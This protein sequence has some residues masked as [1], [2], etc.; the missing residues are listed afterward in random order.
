MRNLKYKTAYT[1]L[2]VLLVGISVGLVRAQDDSGSSSEGAPPAAT[3]TEGPNV[4]NPPLSGLDQPTSE[5]AFGGRSYV[6]PGLQVSES[7]NTNLAGSA[8]SGTNTAAI[9]T[10]LGSMDLQK[11]WR[12]YQLGLDYIAGGSYYTGPTVTSG[13][14]HAYQVHTLAADQRILWRTG[15]LSIRDTFDYLPE[16]A[17]GFNSYGGAGAFSSALGNGVSG[18]GAGTGLG[19]GLTGGSPAGLYAGN[20]YGTLG[21]QPR[22]DNSSIIDIVQEFSP[23]TAVTLGGGYSFSHY[24]DTASSPFPIINSQQ[25]TG[26]VGY[27]YLLNARDQIGLL[28]AFQEFQ[29][30]RAGGGS[31]TAHVWNVLYGHRI[32]GRLNFTLAGGPQ[33]IFIHNPMQVV[34]IPPLGT[35]T[36]PASVTRRVSGNGSVTL[37]YTVSAR[38]SAQVRYQHYVTPGSGFYA[39]ANTDAVR[40]SLGHMFGRHWTSMTDA[41]YSHNSSLKQITSASPGVHSRAYQYWY[42]GAS[43]Q[44]NL[45]RQFG[46]FLAYQYNDMTLGQCAA[47]GAVCGLSSKR[48]TGAVGINWHP[49]PIRLD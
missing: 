47:S 40:M 7:V 16:G 25:M 21:F 29:F 33:M 44:R 11:I 3:G 17:F 23:R 15:Q 38:T 35:L 8:G 32:S 48:N 14:S 28:Y 42:A 9:T 4:E 36:I 10:G 2:T 30:P 45:G 46:I 37:A 13:K 49:K 22:I 20:G 6:V 41:G 12:R 18:T 24:F 34:P 26:Q 43:L 27:N 1:L 39:G 31:V 5:P 19:G